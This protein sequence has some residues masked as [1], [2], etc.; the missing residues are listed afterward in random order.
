ML[1]IVKRTTNM[2][3]I[4]RM[5]T[6]RHHQYWCVPVCGKKKVKYIFGH[7]KCLNLPEVCRKFV[8]VQSG[9]HDDDFE[10]RLLKFCSECLSC[11]DNAK[12][13]VCVHRTL[14]SLVQNHP[15]VAAQLRIYT[16]NATTYFLRRRQLFREF[17]FS[18]KEC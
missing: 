13:N 10:G 12:Q 15:R 7:K 3:N 8:S 1:P 9:G 11:F 2:A 5:L 14:V 4:D 6:T 18:S 16:K 17:V